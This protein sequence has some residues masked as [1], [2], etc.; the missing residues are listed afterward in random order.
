M[1]FSANI[2][3][4]FSGAQL[5]LQL[6]NCLQ[7]GGA[8]VLARPEVDAAALVFLS[9]VGVSFLKDHIRIQILLQAGHVYIA[10]TFY[11]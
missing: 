1:N 6:A 11:D 7:Q 2:P 4:V 3:G 10:L 9:V 5:Q 8:I